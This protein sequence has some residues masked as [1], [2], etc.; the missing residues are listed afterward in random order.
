ELDAVLYDLADGLRAVA[1]ALVM[2][3][4]L[5]VPGFE[6]GFLGVDV[7]FVLS[8]FLI[9]SLALDEIDR[10][11]TLSLTA[12]WA[13]RIRRLVPA[14]VVF[15]LVVATVTSMSA[16]LTERESVRSDLVATASYVANWRFIETS[17]YF[18]SNGIESPVEH[19]WSLAVEEQFYLGWP[20]AL[21][22]VGLLT[23]W[24]RPRRA[25]GVLAGAGALLS[26]VAMAALWDP[27]AVERAYM[28][29]DARI[30]EPL[31]GACGA[32]VIGPARVRALLDRAGP[33]LA[34]AGAA[35]LVASLAWI[36]PDGPAYYRGGA[37]LVSLTTLAIVAPVWRGAAGPIGAA[38]GRSPLARIGEISYG[39]YLWHWPIILWL[40][41]RE[42]AASYPIAVAIA[43]VVLTVGAAAASFA[44]VEEPFRRRRATGRHAKRWVP[45]RAW[46]LAA[47]PMSLV[48]VAGISM[49]ATVVPPPTPGDPV[50]MLVGDSVPEHLAVTI[51][52]RSADRGWRIVSASHGS[53]PV[54]GEV[55]TY[56]G[57]RPV[58]EADACSDRIVPEQ[59]ALIASTDPDL[60]VWWDRW[61]ISSFLT[62]DGALARSGTPRFWRERREALRE[63]VG[64][65]S[66]TGATVVLVATEPPGRNVTA[67]C[68]EDRCHE[69]LE[70]QVT[71]YDDVTSRWNTM[72]RN[73]A[74]R[75]PRQAVFVTITDVVCAD[76][77]SPCDDTLAGMPAR[78]DGTH[79]EGAGAELV[80]DALVTRLAPYMDD[81]A[82]A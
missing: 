47:A 33:A 66:S 2:L 62:S 18:E 9:T 59:D 14:L 75:H 65:L 28:G 56:L 51:E 12:F 19:A 38:L 36:R 34:V 76:H 52:E 11:R 68:T 3:F 30:F 81:A 73:Y 46:V 5:R 21:L 74:D 58:R 53:C 79:Y 42:P 6:A 60:V 43:A 41:L 7:F 57:G 50:V 13:R 1:V 25:V 32:A 23:R 72:L 37:V 17:S 63:T 45:S 54:T 16:T 67:R 26:V 10:T 35:G 40:G 39:I 70:F 15:L 80:S 24:R 48:V 61:S 71:R 55:A 4:H 22:A 20:L 78:P 49:A 82:R 69:W 31:I 77:V 8:G 64:R 44:L 29:T 27:A